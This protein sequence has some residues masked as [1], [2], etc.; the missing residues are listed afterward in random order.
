VFHPYPY[1]RL[2][3][4][5]IGKKIRIG[6]AGNKTNLHGQIAEHLGVSI[7]SGKITP[8][9]VLPTEAGLG[10]SL[11]V[12]RTAIREAIKVLTSKGLVEVRRKT[13]TR[14]RPKKDWNALDPDVVA[15]Q[16][17]GGSLPA[18]IMD[19]LELREIIE[20]MCARMAAERATTEEV[21]EIE[22]ALVEMERSVGKT[23]ASVEADLWF[24][25]AILEA[26]H[27]SL[28]RPFGALIQAALRASFR[29]TNRD[30][31]AYQQT[32]LKHRM[33]L[34]A[35]K[36]KSPGAAEDAMRAVIHG[37]RHDIQQALD[38]KAQKKRILTEEARSTRV[39]LRK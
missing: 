20:P 3:S 21:A 5:V 14:V 35:I 38:A 13:G 39:R 10:A 27:N 1:N 33:V 17:S 22:K 34:T 36:G 7:L 26:T 2:V 11:H 16:F 28:M 12:S 4:S 18:A 30:T 37:A 9:E 32:L 29:Q 19:L 23:T 25:L 31:A 8:G 24:H 6:G 15:W